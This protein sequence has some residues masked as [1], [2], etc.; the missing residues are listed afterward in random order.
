MGAHGR[1]FLSS[2]RGNSG[3]FVFVIVIFGDGFGASCTG[4]LRFMPQPCAIGRRAKCS[5]FEG[6]GGATSGFVLFHAGP[7]A[8]QRSTAQAQGGRASL[9][10]PV[11]PTADGVPT[12]LQSSETAPKAPGISDFCEKQHCSTFQGGMLRFQARPGPA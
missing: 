1:G 11:G 7:I 4:M 9:A 3:I 8:F 12:R 6:G 2:N 10:V 5:G